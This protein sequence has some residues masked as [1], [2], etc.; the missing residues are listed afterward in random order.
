MMKSKVSGAWP[1]RWLIGG[2]SPTNAPY[3]IVFD[4]A[5]N[6][7]VIYKRPLKE[8]ERANCK[9]PQLIRISEGAR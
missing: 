6:K 1:S 7:S 9:A 3:E 4:A 2:S 8:F 5:G